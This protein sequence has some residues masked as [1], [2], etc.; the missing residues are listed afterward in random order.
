MQTAQ[1]QVSALVLKNLSDTGKE[2]TCHYQGSELK[3][4]VSSV[5]DENMGHAGFNICAFGAG[6][7]YLYNVD[8]R[9][10]LQSVTASRDGKLF[11]SLKANESCPHVADLVNIL[12]GGGKAGVN[13]SIR[14]FN[15]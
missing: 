13:I 3:V 9:G 1:A 10:K 15:P 14:I 11:V 5:E 4:S 8:T 6:K 2:T 12:N 7:S